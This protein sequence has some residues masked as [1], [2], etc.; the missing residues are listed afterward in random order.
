M[1]VQPTGRCHVALVVETVLEARRPKVKSKPGQLS[2]EEQR[3]RYSRLVNLAHFGLSPQAMRWLNG[4]IVE[5]IMGLRRLRGLVAAENE[6]IASLLLSID[7]ASACGMRLAVAT[8]AAADGPRSSG[9]SDPGM[10]QQAISQHE[11]EVAV[12]HRPLPSAH[13]RAG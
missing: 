8:V 6:R 3:T 11:G 1:V 7:S 13:V 2:D 12:A 5:M 4:N 9:V 10:P